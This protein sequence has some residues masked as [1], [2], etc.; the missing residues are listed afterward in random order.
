MGVANNKDKDKYVVFVVYG[1]PIPL[2]VAWVTNEIM[3]ITNTVKANDHPLYMPSVL[4]SVTTYSITVVIPNLGGAALADEDGPPNSLAG[5]N[6]LKAM[7]RSIS[8]SLAA[9]KFNTE[10]H[11]KKEFKQEVLDAEAMLLKID[12]MDISNPTVTAFRKQLELERAIE[13]NP[14]LKFSATEKV[15]PKKPNELSIGTVTVPLFG[16]TEIENVPGFA[17]LLCGYY[18]KSTHMISG[19]LTGF[20]TTYHPNK[21]TDT[22]VI[23]FQDQNLAALRKATAADINPP[24]PAATT[25]T[26]GAGGQTPSRNP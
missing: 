15:E 20:Q 25:P 14:N 16:V 3:K 8:T 13:K 2:P 7:L 11:G 17:N 19:Y 23:T 26:A 10:P 9:E 1:K 6:V 18:G 5:I 21:G 12:S 24:K 22:W 4:N